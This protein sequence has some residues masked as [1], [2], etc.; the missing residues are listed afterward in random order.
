MG[1]LQTP[2]HA[3]HVDLGARMIHFDGFEMPVQYSSIVEE[4][5]AVR[6][7]TGI[8]DVSHMGEI[9]ILGKDALRFCDYLLTNT[10]AD[11]ND[12]DV[13]YSPM[14]YPDGGQVDDLFVYRLSRQRL[15]LVVNASPA[16]SLKDFNW[17]LGHSTGFDVEVV[18]CSQQYAELAVQGPLSAALLDPL[19]RSPVRASALQ[20]FRFVEGELFG[21]RILVSRTGY[22]GE[23]G[24]EIFLAPEDAPLLWRGIIRAGSPQGTLPC[25]L[26]ARDTLRFEVCYWLYGNDIGEDINP[27]ETGQEWAVKL[28]KPEFIGRTALRM[29]KVQGV[30]RRLAGLRVRTGGIARNGMEVT[31]DGATAGF[32]TS[33][34]YCPSLKGV[35]A[36]AMLGATHRTLGTELMVR[37][38][39]REA[40]AEVVAMPFMAPVNKRQSQS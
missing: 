12:G 8:F 27:L 37:I 29:A 4:H 9:E 19:F 39:D 18:N 2:L 5:L 34:N 24:F 22:T 25:G 20:R 16:H 7:R 1:L 32:V 17:I 13:K 35:Y 6:Q 30:K 21:K 10:F 28:E 38:R 40:P 26:G 3:E 11:M 36:M 33:G 15:L 31:D 14:C 23:D